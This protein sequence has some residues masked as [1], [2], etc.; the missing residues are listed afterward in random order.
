MHST[1][2]FDPNP[3]SDGARIGEVI[4]TTKHGEDIIHDPLLNKGTG[5]LLDERERLGLRGLV[6]PRCPTSH[7]EAMQSGAARILYGYRRLTDDLDKYAYLIAL[8]D[9]NEA[10]FYRV[11][12]DNIEEM[13]PII[14]TPTV[15]KACIAFS[16]IF[17]RTRGMYFSSQD[18]GAMHAMVY[19]WPDDDVEVIVVTDGS[20]ILG[21]GDLGVNGMGIPI[22]KLSLYTAGAG[23]HPGKTLPVMID[24]GTN[25]VKL[26]DDPFYL[27]LKQDRI[28]GDE[29]FAVLHEF[30]RAVH[31]RY[32]KCLIQFEDF[33]SEVALPLLEKYRHRI[34]CFNDDIQGTSV[35]ALA[36]L[37]G[38][39]KQAGQKNQHALIES[40][41]VIVGA[42]SAG[43]GVAEGIVGG[44]VMQGL[45]PEEA[46]S[47]IYVLDAHG[48][49]GRER[50]GLTDLQKLYA[51]DDI[52]DKLSLKDTIE[53]VKPN[54]LM[55]LSGAG[56]AFKEDAIRTMAKHCKNPIIFPLSNPTSQAEC[57]PEQALTWTNGTAVVAS[58]S[59]FDPVVVNGKKRIISQANNF[60]AFPGIGL[61]ALCCQAKKITD[62][63]FY[64]AAVAL[65]R[66]VTEEDES[67]G[68]I[69]P[70]LHQIRRVSQQVALAVCKQAH[71]DGVATVPKPA[72]DEEQL[73]IIRDRMWV[74]RYGSMIKVDSI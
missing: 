63:M 71:I 56:G 20:R 40:R 32:P 51:K 46:R 44:M 38:A 22:G 60:Y 66:T 29:Y 5:F 30:I 1:R 24:V 52:A 58:G 61:G 7:E 12:I 25:N 69:F 4:L 16:S 10:L 54:I 67:S 65:S 26:R 14:Y 9:R 55:G 28:K 53:F 18:R 72:N 68:R 64:A 34:L 11:L 35:V 48:V 8:Q 39:L 21:L 59:P 13:S 23:I 6:P 17:R 74:A 62:S 49:I 19:N 3:N 36:G 37:F 43:L 2:S 73:E 15:G 31:E 50:T 33:S 41:L 70:P 47:R 57:T 45:T 27:G 42:G